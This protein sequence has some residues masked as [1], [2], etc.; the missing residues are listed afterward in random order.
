MNSG[1][2]DVS[3]SPD[4][5]IWN[6]LHEQVRTRQQ[7]KQITKTEKSEKPKI[8]IGI[9]ES[10]DLWEGINMSILKESNDKVKGI[11]WSDM[12]TDQ[13]EK[14]DTLLNQPVKLLKT[15]I[16]KRQMAL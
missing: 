9:T 2:Y 5:G 6:Q 13:A 4:G 1:Q 14:F 7:S 12:E 11:E 8:L 16:L 15:V 10:T 3:P